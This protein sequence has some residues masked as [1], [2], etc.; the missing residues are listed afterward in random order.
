VRGDRFDLTRDR[1]SASPSL[2]TT[3]FFFDR[4]LLVPKSGEGVLARAVRSLHVG[5]TPSGLSERHAQQQTLVC[6]LPTA[7]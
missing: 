4:D 1:R 2:F 3:V 5:T 7:S 6:Q